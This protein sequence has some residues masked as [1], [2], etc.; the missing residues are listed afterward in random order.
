M[1]RLHDMTQGQVDQLLRKLAAAGLDSDAADAVMRSP[2]LAQKWVTDLREQLKPPTPTFEQLF[3]SPE[4]LYAD[5]VAESPQF[6][7][8]FAPKQLE[9]LRR[10]MP[11]DFTSR[12]DSVLVLDVWLGD[13][14]TTFEM[15]W[16]WNQAVHG[17]QNT[18]RYDSLQSWPGKLRLL[19]PERY[20]NQ[21]SVRWVVLDLTA[22]RGERPKDVR[23]AATSPGT[24]VLAAAAL[25][26]EWATAINYDTVPGVW[27]PG[28]QATVP[29][30]R[31]W[32]Y[33]P[34]LLWNRF[35]RTVYLSA[36]WD[37]LWDPDYAVPVF[38]EL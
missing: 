8:R 16:E 6:G 38:R 32:Q 20:G 26:P 27:L 19:D 17:H 10:S 36:H 33:V 31:P 3:R 12:L 4:E 11:V 30:A 25:H 37:G 14:P 15:L 2:E 18:W 28:L 5:F 13:L 1:A 23:N 7:R 24:A 35:F 21:P 29:G 34:L 9:S 22:N